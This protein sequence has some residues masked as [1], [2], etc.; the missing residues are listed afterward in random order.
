MGILLGLSGLDVNTVQNVQST[1]ALI[2]AQQANSRGNLWE[3]FWREREI[4]FAAAKMPSLE[5][6]G[7]RSDFVHYGRSEDVLTLA[8]SSTRRVRAA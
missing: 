3:V 7:A 4:L 6:T 8:Q 1:P 2:A 5:N